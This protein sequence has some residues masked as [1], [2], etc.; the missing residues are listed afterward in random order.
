MWATYELGVSQHEKEKAHCGS[1]HDAGSC[2]AQEMRIGDYHFLVLDYG[3][4]MRLSE[5]AKKHL[6]YGE[7]YGRN[8]R[9]Y[10]DCRSRGVVIAR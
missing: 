4:I 5:R 6:R 3:G 7:E 1:Y 8:Q 9:D 10:I 2:K